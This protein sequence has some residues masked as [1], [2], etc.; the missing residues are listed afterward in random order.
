MK[1]ESHLFGWQH[2][3]F[4]IPENWDLVAEHGHE[5]K[6]Y[7]RLA[8]LDTIRI[9]MKWQGIPK[10][11]KLLDLVADH[12][13]KIGWENHKIL[14]LNNTENAYS[15]EN[16]A[17]EINQQI[18]FL[19][20]NHPKARLAV[21]RIFYKLNE[22]GTKLVKDL[23]NSFEDHLFEAQS[24][25]TYYDCHMVVPSVYK[26]VQANI[27][28]GNKELILAFRNK[29]FYSW[30]I[31]LASHFCPHKPF[32]T[33]TC[34]LWIYELLKNK[35]NKE[36]HFKKEGFLENV[37]SH[38]KTSRVGRVLLKNIFHLSHHWKILTKYH[39]NTDIL[40]IVIFNYKN[41]KD[42]KRFKNILELIN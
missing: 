10:K 27:N 18:L 8:D 36:I 20:T 3:Q 23:V 30:S 29:T 2:F 15:I 26:K 39:Q 6:G 19:K 12:V 4:Q 32:N 13:K 35:F 7:I 17:K 31:S 24:L 25:W 11:A 5:E 38:A 28:A 1:T 41:E 14:K 34:N 42:I 9:E 40:K 37:E 22:N 16:R 21:V 33:Q